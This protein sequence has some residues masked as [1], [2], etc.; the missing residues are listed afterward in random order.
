MEFILGKGSLSNLK[1]VHPDMQKLV[2]AA[3]K[4]TPID[5]TILKNGGLRTTSMQMALF[6]KGASKVNGRTS[7][8]KHQKQD[9]GFGW[10]V[11]L[12]PWVD[13]SARWEWP[14][15]YPI[16][17]TMAR[18]SKEMKIDIRWGGVWD[19]E[20][21]DFINLSNNPEEMTATIKREVG[22]YCSRHGGPDFIDGP[23]YEL[24]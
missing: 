4:E 6:N 8:S 11:D 15:I 17:A 3:I 5:F 10:A 19:R 20:L 23:H 13:G 12:V 16:A 14:L 2:K 7:K 1:G 21:D 24:H 22:L 18:L 9:D